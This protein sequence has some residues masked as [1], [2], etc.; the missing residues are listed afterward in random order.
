MGETEMCIFAHIT[1][2]LSEYFAFA[3]IFLIGCTVYT[4]DLVLNVN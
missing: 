4:L 2:K 3:F 1:Y